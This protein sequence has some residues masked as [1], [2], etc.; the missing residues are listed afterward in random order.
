M[1]HKLHTESNFMVVIE[2]ALET[3]TS[4]CYVNMNTVITL[5]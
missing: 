5:L 1:Q 3:L 2:N 4:K